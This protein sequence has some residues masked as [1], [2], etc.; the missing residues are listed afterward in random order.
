M[1]DAQNGVWAGD[2][3]SDYGS[4]G[5]SVDPVEPPSPT[6]ENTA[7]GVGLAAK[8][9]S[10]FTDAGGRIASYT[11]VNTQTSGSC[12]WSGSGLGPY[13]PS[14]SAGDAGTLS[15]NA[16][17]SSG[18]VVAT[19]VHSYER[20]AA[21]GGLTAPSAVFTVDFSDESPA[22]YSA[23][24]G[25]TR[26][27]DSADFTSF[28]DSAEEF[29]PDGST[30]WVIEALNAAGGTIV[31]PGLELDVVSDVSLDRLMVVTWKLVSISLPQ[32]DDYVICEM[33]GTTTPARRGPGGG[34]WLLGDGKL[35]IVCR[36]SGSNTPLTALKTT[37]GAVPT[38]LWIRLIADRCSGMVHI[39]YSTSAPNSTQLSGGM[40]FAGV[41][42]NADSAEAASTAPNAWPT[43]WLQQCR[44]YR[45]TGGGGSNATMTIESMTVTELA[46]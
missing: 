4:G 21:A 39:Y 23:D 19:A 40:T 26:T 38:T 7:S 45:A 16:L 27:V 5:G 36:R 18:D 2:A 43:M 3:W 33:L 11:A 32:T 34:I 9:F 28:G 20:D 41:S 29:G 14:D 13:T 8:T 35:Y 46:R 30:G 17:D 42:V 37:L 15:L 31:G 1:P 12:T 24:T 10:A 25:T 6:S 22:D 44:L